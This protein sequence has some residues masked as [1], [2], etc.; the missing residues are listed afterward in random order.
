[1]VSVS[2][3][4]F[5]GFKKRWWAFSQM[6]KG[7]QLFK[8]TEG[9]SF[10]KMMG[11]GANGGFSI[12]PNFGLYGVICVWENAAAQEHFFEYNEELALFRKNSVA[13]QDIFLEPLS[14]HGAWDKQNPFK[15]TTQTEKTPPNQ[16]IAVITRATIYWQKLHKFWYYVPSA[17]KNMQNQEGLRLA[18][19]IG[20]LPL[21]QQATFSIWDNSQAM[22]QYAY[23]NKSHKVVIEKTRKYQ[24]YK[25]ELFARF[26][27]KDVQGNLWDSLL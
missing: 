1:M 11:S 21:I 10:K 6:G 2:F 20:E 26:A 4:K 13:H 3:F 18:L 23:K 9:L 27:V 5:Q 16:K 15:I 12:F 17:S 22:Q 24:W 19:G 8:N 25:E 14:S 7:K